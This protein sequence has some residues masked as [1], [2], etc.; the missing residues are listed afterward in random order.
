VLEIGCGGGRLTWTLAP[1]VLARGCAYWATDVTRLFLSHVDVRAKE[2]GLGEIRT[3]LLDITRDPV[4][5]GF[6]PGGFDAVVGLDVVHVAPRV[7]EALG[8]LRKLLVPDGLLGLVETVRDDR[9]HSMIWGLSSDWWH[10]SHPERA[11]SPLVSAGGWRRLMEGRG[12]ARVSAI[13]NDAVDDVAVVL[14]R[15]GQGVSSGSAA[16]E[17]RIRIEDLP[18]RRDDIA[19]WFSVP[20]WRRGAPLPP[21]RAA[22]GR[23][24]ALVDEG[25]LGAA[26]AELLE[27]AGLELVPL[28]YR[29]I[30][31]FEQTLGDLVARGLRP[32]LVLHGWSLA[33]APSSSGVELDQAQARGLHALLALARILGPHTDSS[34]TR[35]VVLAA[36]TQEVTG[37]EL[38][39]PERASVLA[40][41]KVIPREYPRFECLVIDAPAVRDSAQTE[42]LAELAVREAMG[43]ARD[44]IVA[45]RA[46]HR[47]LPTFEGVRL[48]TAHTPGPRS[49]RAGRTYL[50]AGGLGGIGL[51]M[52]EHLARRGA[53]LVLTSRTPVPPRSEWPARATGS[54]PA[55]GRIRRLLALSET[56]AEILALRADVASL[57]DMRTVAESARAHFGGI[58]GVI[59]SAGV[60]DRAG[61]IQR[62]TRE[63]TD[64][65]LRAKLHGAFVLEHVFGD[66]RLD[67]F[68][69]CCSVGSLLYRLKFGEV[70]YV[71]GND[72]LSAFAQRRAATHGD[73]VAIA[74][75]DWTEAGMWA[76]ARPE[77]SRRYRAAGGEG[78]NALAVDLLA[79]LSDVEGVEALERIL[80]G[81]LPAVVVTTQPMDQLLAAHDRLTVQAHQALLDDIDLAAVSLRSS[82]GGAGGPLRTPTERAVAA[83]W[84]DL[85][86][87]E[88]IGREDS[89]FEL[90]GDSLVALRLLGRLRAEIGVDYSVARLFETPRLGE[91]AA[92]LV[93]GV[94]GEEDPEKYH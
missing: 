21:P 77:L 24:L 7:G 65:A 83:I 55:A 51:A 17:A 12:F 13:T 86:G 27:Q 44:P 16:P 34:P 69:V 57:E 25:G 81:D 41:G 29:G 64:L 82:S 43:P 47:W 18:G 9:W 62:R 53:R 20:S 1:A 59:H 79:G 63:D 56:G 26:V 45:L 22:Q 54:D 15:A 2:R 46:P 66:R 73:A 87:V 90:G 89:F 76:S 10:F 31:E 38:T 52:A 61:V 39:H 60:P 33:G 91:L 40:A 42:R 36:G 74:W 4:S 67:F 75:T 19:D 92:A 49:P 58:D 94:G 30:D 48:A 8:N 35:L 6:A 68:A 85:L 11:R 71:A 3:A 23:C 80:A 93:G 78:A 32:T 5:Q 50:I 84:H 28:R 14:G 37:G 88:A 72:V 70:G